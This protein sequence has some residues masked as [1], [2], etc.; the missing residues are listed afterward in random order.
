MVTILYCSE[1]LPQLLVQAFGRFH[2]GTRE[3]GGLELPKGAKQK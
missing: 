1:C 3:V 2:D